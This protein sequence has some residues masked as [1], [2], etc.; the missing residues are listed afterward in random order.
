MQQNHDVQIVNSNEELRIK[1]AELESAKRDLAEIK[2]EGQEEIKTRLIEK[3]T[4]HKTEL[5]K[6]KSTY[7]EA[8]NKRV[9]DLRLQY[10]ER[11]EILKGQINTHDKHYD[12][13]V[14]QIRALESETEKAKKITK[15]KSTA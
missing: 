9:E 3:E 12:N 13:W 10:E 15:N 5:I 7:Q 2:S 1:V 14:H 11:I 6:I 4:E 8:L